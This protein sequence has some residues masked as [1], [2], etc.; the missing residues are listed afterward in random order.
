MNHILMQNRAVSSTIRQQVRT[1]QGALHHCLLLYTLTQLD[2]YWQEAA[3]PSFPIPSLNTPNSTGWHEQSQALTITCTYS[4]T[5][6]ST[7]PPHSPHVA[8]PT[9]HHI[10]HGCTPHEH[11]VEN[12]VP[13]TQLD[14]IRQL[15]VFF[16]PLLGAGCSRRPCSSACRGVLLER[17]RLGAAAGWPPPGGTGQGVTISASVG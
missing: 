17:A 5:H 1:R 9:C 15:P 8:E 6:R 12:E 3:I 2:P 4:H 11:A 16:R 13:Q 14:A 10:V 7:S